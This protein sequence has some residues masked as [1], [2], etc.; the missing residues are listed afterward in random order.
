MKILY[1]NACVRAASRTDRLAR[2]VIQKSAGLGDTVEEVRLAQLDLQPLSEERLDRRT[3][4]IRQGAWEAPM[5]A[6]ARQFAAADVIVMAA[7]YWDGSFPALLKLY[8]ENIYVTGLVSQ[9]SPEGRPVGLCRAQRLDYVVTAGGPYDDRFSYRYLEA[10]AKNFFGIAQTRLFV[11][12]GLDLVGCDP[13]AIL[14]E[15]IAHI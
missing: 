6:L 14:V 7:P 9:Y 10:L 15:A 8:I 1:V 11:A 13:E 2:A 3:G 5:F 12:E 4:L